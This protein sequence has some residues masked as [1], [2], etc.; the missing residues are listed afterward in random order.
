MILESFLFLNKYILMAEPDHVFVRPL[1]NLARGGYTAGFPFF[2]I[3]P[4]EN[5]KLIRKFYLEE[6]GPVTNVDP[7]GNSPVIIKNVEFLVD[8]SMLKKNSPTWMNV[9]ISMKNDPETDKT[10]GW[11][12]EIPPWDLEVGKN[13][14][15]HYTY[16]CDY[17][18]KV[19]LVTKVNEA[20]TNIPGWDTF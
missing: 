15:I 17:S 3:K 16:G 9:S 20:T 19:M 13:F 1:P 12:L 4:A 14:I 2:Y 18:L 11:V 5:E 7:I 6:K 10:F 8:N